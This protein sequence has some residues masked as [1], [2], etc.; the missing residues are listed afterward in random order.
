VLNTEVLNEIRSTLEAEFCCY[1]YRNVTS[2]L[3]DKAYLI[4]HKKV[5]RIMDENKLLLG[6]VI[7]SNGKRCFVQHRRID[8]SRP[9]EYLCL[10]I[11]YVCEYSGQRGPLNP[12][13]KG[14]VI[15]VERGPLYMVDFAC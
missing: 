4:N 11:K 13:Q 5:Y 2:V 6:K 12:V 3:R 8:A 9:M 15:T 10:D 14:P 7:S 1:G